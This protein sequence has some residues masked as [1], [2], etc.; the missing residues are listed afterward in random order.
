MLS[1]EEIR[2]K[3]KEREAKDAADKVI[4]ARNKAL[5]GKVG[6]AKLVWKMLSMD[7]DIF[8]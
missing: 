1:V 2:V 4:K 8:E 5:R 3:A 7:I 6:F